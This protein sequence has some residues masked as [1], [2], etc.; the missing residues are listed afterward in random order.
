ML[1]SRREARFTASPMTVYSMRFSLPMLPATTGPVWMPMPVRRAGMPHRVHGVARLGHGRAEDGHDGVADVLVDD[2][3]LFH[4][5][6]DHLAEV[7]VEQ[8]HELLRVHALAQRG[9]AAD[10][11]EQDGDLERLAAQGDLARHEVVHHA[12][13]HV[14]AE[15][16]AQLVALLQAVDH[17]VEARGERLELVAGLDL[18]AVHVVELLD[19]LHRRVHAQE[20]AR[21][22][23][24][25]AAAERHRD[26]RRHREDRQRVEQVPAHDGVDVAHVERG[27]HAHV[28]EAAVQLARL[29]ALDRPRPVARVDD[30][31]AFADGDARRAAGELLR[32]PHDLLAAAQDGQRELEAQLGAG[33]LQVP[34]VDR[35]AREHRAP[36]HQ[37]HADG[38]G[39]RRARRGRLAPVLD[40]R[41]EL[42]ALQ[43]PGH[44]G[45]LEHVGRRRVAAHL[46]EDLAVG[47]HEQHVDVRVHVEEHLGELPR[48]GRV[49]VGDGARGGAVGG[50]DA[51]RE[52]EIAEIVVELGLEGALGVGH[53]V[54]HLVDQLPVQE[55]R[56]HGQRREHDDH[57]QRDQRG[58]LGPDGRE[59]EAHEG[60]IVPKLR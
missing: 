3:V 60:V 2:P 7:L 4:H 40:D 20:G 42:V 43:H 44:L 26:H 32:G 12:R 31:R 56:E 59:A 1:L 45:H 34:G 15:G 27:H 8:A 16:G 13:R 47:L 39:R 50:Q 25:E 23:V 18:G 41:L 22:D 58:E 6:A 10:V 11:G 37:R 29:E 51:R 38:V 30:G 36:A 48:P 28:A 49:V 14:L 24:R 17:G 19:A 52:R 21:H 9:E 46:R 35:H 54:V 5:D 55:P 33:V 57:R 53:A